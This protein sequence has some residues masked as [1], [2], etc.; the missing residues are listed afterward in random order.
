LKLPV[1]QHKVEAGGTQTKSPSS[2]Q[3]RAA[4]ARWGEKAAR[5]EAQAMRYREMNPRCDRHVMSLMKPI[6]VKIV[7][8]S[9]DSSFIWGFGCTQC[10]RR[11]SPEW[12]YFKAPQEGQT[13]FPPGEQ[14]QCHDHP[15]SR[16]VYRLVEECS[17]TLRWTC[18]VEHCDRSEPFDPEG[19]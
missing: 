5:K 4:R 12:G 1:A 2:R 17:G 9:G 11:Y 7:F 3:P 14:S 19:A 6:T 8:L 18:P 10:E 15:S 16:P 13:E